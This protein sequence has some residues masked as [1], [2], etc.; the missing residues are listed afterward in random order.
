MNEINYNSALDF[1]VGDWVEFYNSGSETV[2]LDG[3]E[4]RDENDVHV[5]AFEPGTMIAPGEYLLL[6]ED[7]A[8]FLAQFPGTDPLPGNTGF[9][10][11]G[12]GELL[13]LYDD[14]GFLHDSLE[15]NDVPPWPPE[16]DGDG[17]TLELIHFTRDNAAAE[18]WAASSG[19]APHGTPGAQNS[20][21]DETAAPV[22]PASASL[23]APFPNPFNP[24][25]RL[26]FT[27]ATAGPARLSIHDIRGRELTRLADGPLASG[28]HSFDWQARDVYGREF[29]AGVYLVRLRAA[30]IL[31]SRKIVL[32]K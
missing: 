31:Q 20:T 23:A 30:G 17:P 21:F 27:L 18:N 22:T 5:Y 25:T 12:G 28:S 7:R 29:P 19:A 16:A 1:V 11:S 4:F 6:C 9:G 8:A 2:D 24:S 26:S 13:R 14:F 3:W 32:L 10:F 15:Y